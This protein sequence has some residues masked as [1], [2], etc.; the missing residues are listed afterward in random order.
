M[1]DIY[2]A[3]FRQ[4][5]LILM[6]TLAGI[7]AAVVYYFTQPPPFQ[8][9][10]ELMVRYIVDT[11]TANG[12]A[13][14][15]NTQ[16]TTPSE[17][18][19]SIVNAEMYILASFDLAQMVVSNIG[20][21]RILAA[22]GGGNSL[23]SSAIQV[24]NHLLVEAPPRSTI[25]HLTFTHPDPSLVQ[26]V[27]RE[28]VA[29]YLIKSLQVHQA[30]G[31]SYDFLSEQTSL[32]KEQI[33]QT[34]DEI[35]A[36]KTN[37]GIISVE[38]SDKTFSEQVAKIEEDLFQSRAQLA[39][40]QALLHSDTNDTIAALINMPADKMDEYQRICDRLD[41]L[42]RKQNELVTEHGYKDSNTWVKE[43]REQIEALK[44]ELTDKYPGLA[45]LT[46]TS[47][48]SVSQPSPLA[49]GGIGGLIPLLTKIQILEQQKKQ[50]WTQA[51]DE[52]QAKSKIL[53]LQR[54]KQIED[55]NYQ[56]FAT[57][58]EQAQ[59][60]EAIGPGR[61]SNIAE[62]EPP[63]P[64][65]KDLV[66]F[67]KMVLRLLGG[68]VL[69]GL[70]LALL[71]E[72]LIDQRVKRPAEIEA[73]LHLRLFL[74]IP[75]FAGNWKKTLERKRPLPLLE[76]SLES[77]GGEGG[78]PGG[79]PPESPS[80][81]PVHEPRVATGADPLL[82]PYYDTL[83]DRLISYF[84]GLDLT[85]KPKLVAV[86]STEKGAGVSSIAAGLADSLSE[87]GDGRVLLV[88]MNLE[89][90][91]GQTYFNGK[92]ACELE[93]A[94]VAEKRDDALVQENLYVVEEISRGDKRPRVLPKRFAMLMPKF[95][96]SDY[97][98]IIFDMPPVSQTSVTARLAGLVDMTLL[99]VEAEKSNREVVRQAGLLLTQ[100]KAT[101]GAVLNKTKKYVPDMLHQDFLEG[102]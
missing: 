93:D 54:K 4:K 7:A 50:I 92:P 25:I 102:R 59:L 76:S 64:P 90:D 95:K 80:G 71:L 51:A 16:T 22:Y 88:K 101:V 39:G 31:T 40:Y 38:Q 55:A 15:N 11:R 1:G 10:A 85:R 23:I 37:A 97:D 74:V 66:K 69:T 18:A 32:L 58:L 82:F 87:T 81:P 73:K 48:G 77:S 79:D 83:R 96:A 70:A 46:T 78:E 43:G 28:V 42:S 34:E 100:S 9:D 65:Y 56:Y 49:P 99:V 52:D 47:M 13:P 75:D 29:D 68:G 91:A 53:D 45:A 3:L 89:P 63:T 5:W 2:F 17:M 62:F 60:D 35:R 98:Y 86:T 26:P 67:N 27:L 12:P 14:A 61:V 20:P 72:L 44:K 8:S 33:I 19:D 6:F 84:E 57:T 36:A 30:G 94:L 24:R 41:Y 21:E